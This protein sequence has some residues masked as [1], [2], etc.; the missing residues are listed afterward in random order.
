M[1]DLIVTIMSYKFADSSR[2]ELE[3]MLGLEDFKKTRLGQEM[4]TEGRQEGEEVG[5]VKGRQA[6]RIIGEEFGS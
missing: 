4:L 1:V 6:I 3:A 5:L 2:E